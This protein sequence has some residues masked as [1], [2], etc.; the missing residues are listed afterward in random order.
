MQ[1]LSSKKAIM[2]P[3][4]AA[5]NF[6]QSTPN[7]VMSRVNTT[8]HIDFDDED[9][10][11]FANES[12]KDEARLQSRALLPKFSGLLVEKKQK[13]LQNYVPNP[14]LSIKQQIISNSHLTSY[15]KSFNTIL[16]NRELRAPEAKNKVTQ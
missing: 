3:F 4:T 11:E 15:R 12:R 14:M 10:D 6:Q 5:S 9:M 2:N 13:S 16:S 8:E 7:S 1:R